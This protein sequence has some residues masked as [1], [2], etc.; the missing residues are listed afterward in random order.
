MACGP[1]SCPIWPDP[2]TTQDSGFSLSSNPD[3]QIAMANSLEQLK[4]FTTVVADTG[5]INGK[6]SEW[7]D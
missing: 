1:T 3:K 6:S 5:D 2:N 7:A 4:K